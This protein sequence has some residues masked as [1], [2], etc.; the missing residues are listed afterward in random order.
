M[1]EKESRKPAAPNKVTVLL[2]AAE[3]ERFDAYCHER[4]Y[5]KSTLIARLVRQYLD[6]EG[7]GVSRDNPFNRF[8][9]GPAK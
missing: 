7:F 5:K 9:R 4:G 6:L 8:G 2:D 3:F 1:G